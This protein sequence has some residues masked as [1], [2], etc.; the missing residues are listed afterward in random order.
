[1]QNTPIPM[2]T[3]SHY[4]TLAQQQTNIG[5]AIVSEM[6][7][8]NASHALKPDDPYLSGIYRRIGIKGS[9]SS[10][11]CDPSIPT[12]LCSRMARV[13]D[14]YIGVHEMKI[15]HHNPILL[16]VR[17]YITPSKHETLNKCWIDVG[18]AS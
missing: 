6:D 8:D 15:N 9:Q 10:G 1:M 5:P 7:I 4:A 2:N 11:R 3:R 13:E 14:T 12:L 16:T 17:K 18:P